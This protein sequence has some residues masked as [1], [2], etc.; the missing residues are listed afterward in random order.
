MAFSDDARPVHQARS[1]RLKIAAPTAR[2]HPRGSRGR[3]RRTCRVRRLGTSSAASANLYLVKVALLYFNDCPS[4]QLAE[5]RLAEALRCVGKP[6][7]V[8]E[9]ILI[10]SDDDA[11]E[12]RF[13]GSPTIRIDGQDLFA[14]SDT[15]PFGLTCR[16]YLAEGRPTGSPTI[17]E[18]VTSLTAYASRL[19]TLRS[20]DL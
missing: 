9:R 1:L 3:A 13:P 7:Q 8:V 5:Q 18:F 12:A 11:Q 6:D 4:W 17:E 15:G 20:R 19:R 2:S 10:T 14:V 16:I